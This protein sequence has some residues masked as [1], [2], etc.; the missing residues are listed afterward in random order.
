M[1]HNILVGIDGTPAS[2]CAL[3]RAIEIAREDRAR[4]TILTAVAR[5]SA[6]AAASG[7]ARV[8]AQLTE[9]LRAEAH[10]RLKEA[11]AGVPAE[12][13]VTTLISLQPVRRA[14]LARVATGCHDLL[15][16]GTRG[17][18]GLRGTLAG[19]VSRHL[20]QHCGVPVLVVHAEEQPGRGHFAATRRSPGAARPGELFA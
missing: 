3:R 11:V 1:F 16:V 5:P 17:L 12:I 6:L 8:V 19:S 18:S 7:D 9:D 2:A 13:P 10:E 14:L 4:L 15:V 20:V